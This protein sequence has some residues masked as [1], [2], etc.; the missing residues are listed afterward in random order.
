MQ[1]A[2]TDGSKNK[3]N[4]SEFRGLSPVIPLFILSPLAKR[5]ASEKIPKPPSEIKFYCLLIELT[6]FVN[7]L[8]NSCEEICPDAI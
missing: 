2:K 5:T 3:K 7:S 8:T 6:A 1:K 4:K